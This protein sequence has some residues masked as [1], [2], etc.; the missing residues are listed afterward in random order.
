VRPPPPLIAQEARCAAEWK[1]FTA[2]EVLEGI[3]E[4]VIGDACPMR[5]LA[6]EDDAYWSDSAKAVRGFLFRAKEAKKIATLGDLLNEDITD[7]I[8]EAARAAAEAWAD[9]AS[10]LE[11]RSE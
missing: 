3:S 4:G 5:E 9:L 11:K 6:A 1:K 2:Q 8:I 10:Q 7:E